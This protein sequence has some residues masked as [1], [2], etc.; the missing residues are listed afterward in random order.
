MLYDYYIN[1]V[2]DFYPYKCYNYIKGMI[3]NPKKRKRG[4]RYGIF[5]DEL[6]LSRA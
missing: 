1:N 2:I 3:L 5:S 6:L 4:N